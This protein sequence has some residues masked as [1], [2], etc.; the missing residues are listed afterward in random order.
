MAQAVADWLVEFSSVQP[1]PTPR[2]VASRQTNWMAPPPTVYKINYDG[3]VSLSSN[4]SGIGA[5]IQNS[6]GLVVARNGNGS[7]SGR[8][9]LYPNP[10]H[11]SD[12]EART[13][14]VY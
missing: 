9:S 2:V 11:G 8:V 1:S 5:M 10:T 3:A 7:G 13:R 12:S 14:P 4:C 6:V